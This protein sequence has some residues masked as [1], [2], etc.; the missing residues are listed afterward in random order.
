MRVSV[1]KMSVYGCRIRGAVFDNTVTAGKL[2]WE[3]GMKYM[4]LL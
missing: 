1:F 3:D 4:A 2:W